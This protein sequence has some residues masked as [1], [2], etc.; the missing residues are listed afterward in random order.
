MERPTPEFR[1]DGDATPKCSNP[2]SLTV[3]V[4]DITK[5]CAIIIIIIVIIS[6]FYLR[7]SSSSLNYSHLIRL[8]VSFQVA[9]LL[10]KNAG[11]FI[12]SYIFVMVIVEEI[13]CHIN[14]HMSSKKISQKT[15]LQQD[16]FAAIGLQ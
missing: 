10:D 9:S 7:I 14:M 16:F 12:K 5:D 1:A 13:I 2:I 3:K 8:L 4:I 15:S 6:S 11:T